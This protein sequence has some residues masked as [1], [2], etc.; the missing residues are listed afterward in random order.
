MEFVKLTVTFVDEDDQVISSKDYKYGTKAEDIEVP[1][2]PE[3][4]ADAKYTYTFKGW[5]SE[6]ADVTEEAT[7][8]AT[9][10]K[11]DPVK[12]IKTAKG[13]LISGKHYT[14]KKGSVEITILPEYLETLE[15][16]KT[17]VTV[18]FEDG[19]PVTIELE[20]VAAQ[21]Q[22]DTNPTT[23]DQMNYIWIF[24]GIGAAALAI[25]LFVQV[26]RRRR[27]EEI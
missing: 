23:G 8:K 21:Q 4:K 25:V 11:K 27:E 20:V 6:L 2:A 13:E 19:D 3:K 10:I 16:G 17:A 15:V 26:Q 9:E 5:D 1:E 24:F 22:T 7:Y 12:G 18:S 14:A